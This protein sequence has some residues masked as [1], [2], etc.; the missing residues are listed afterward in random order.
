LRPARYQITDDGIFSLG[1]EV[2]VDE[3]DQDSIVEKGRLAPGEMIAIDTAAGILL[4]DREIKQSIA[5]R[6]NYRKM[7]GRPLRARLLR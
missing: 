1:S 4:R 2:G 3:L 5:T 7:A 6:H